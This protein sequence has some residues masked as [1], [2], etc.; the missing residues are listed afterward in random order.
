MITTALAISESL[1]Y[2]TESL[3]DTM[4][5]LFDKVHPSGT[6]G[7]LYTDLIREEFE[8]WLQEESGTPEDFK[9]IC[10]LIWVCIMYTIE[11]K[12]PLE[13]GMKAL[14][15]EFVSKMV[16]D[17][18]NL[19]PTYRADGKMLKGKHFHKADFRKLLGVAS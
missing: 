2:S 1:E 15:E 3:A 17:N 13:L 19:C 5:R 10:D 16:D 14:G 18:G 12:Y 8:E 7:R 4:Q 9:E 6:S 11:H